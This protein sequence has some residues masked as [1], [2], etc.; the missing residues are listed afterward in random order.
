MARGDRPSVRPP[1]NGERRYQMVVAYDGS[2][3]HGFAASP[4]VATVGGTLA[5]A[6][7]VVLQREVALSCAGRTDAGVHA[8]GQIVSFDAVT[9][10]PAQL[11]SSLN[12]LCAPSIVVRSIE[13][14][15]DGFDARHSAKARTYRYRVLNR[16]VPDPFH[17]GFSWHV[18]DELDIE[19][20]NRAGAE[21][22]GEH[23]FASFCRKRFVTI[24][25]ERIEAPLR[26][27]VLELEWRRV[28]PRVVGGPDAGII[29]LWITATAFCHQMVR[30]I[31][32]TLVD[33]GRGALTGDAVPT[34]LAA[35]DRG[36]VGRVAP[37]N[38]LTLW[39]VAY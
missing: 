30:S 7:G 4:G 26:R 34:I 36:A 13:V 23:D 32:G 6:L 39:S 35:R 14:V 24:D 8:W 16:D 29:E 3:F 1:G 11:R 31:V 18:S 12:S 9:L 22:L 5:D 37:P 28:T 20:M 27:N 38:G 17:G 33:V 15:G 25:G 19:A 21:L 2:A 10:V